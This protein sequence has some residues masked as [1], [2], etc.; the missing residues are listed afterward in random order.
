MLLIDF[1]V[2]RNLFQCS[3]IDLSISTQN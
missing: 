1:S 3:C 2:V